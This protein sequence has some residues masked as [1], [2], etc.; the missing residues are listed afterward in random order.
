M[1]R[2]FLLFQTNKTISMSFLDASLFFLV[3]CRCA[4]GCVCM[5]MP[6]YML[7]FSVSVNGFYFCVFVYC[8]EW[9]VLTL[10]ECVLSIVSVCCFMYCM[11]VC[12]RYCMSVCLCYLGII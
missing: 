12:F 8:A 3:A 1:Y 9:G 5:K 10:N 4:H 2:T 6:V 11:R 7:T